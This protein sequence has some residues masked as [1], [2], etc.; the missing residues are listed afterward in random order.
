MLQCAIKRD[1]IRGNLAPNMSSAAKKILVTGSSGLIGSEAG[2]H[3]DRPGHQV[4]GID[5]NMRRVVFGEEGDTTWNLERPRHKNPN[6]SHV[7][8]GTRDP[9]ALQAP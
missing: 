9:S 7:D 4:I 1:F 6:F 8:A 3:F 2:E 5:N